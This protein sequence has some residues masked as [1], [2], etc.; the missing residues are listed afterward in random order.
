MNIQY[1]KQQ[2]IFLFLKD[3]RRFYIIIGIIMFTL[4][5]SAVIN[6]TNNKKIRLLLREKEGE[7][8]K[9]DLLNLINMSNKTISLYKEAFRPRDVFLVMSAVGDIAKSSG[10]KLSSIKPARE[11]EEPLYTRYYFNLDVEANSYHAIGKFVGEIENSPDTY[12]VEELDIKIREDG[13]ASGDKGAVQEAKPANKFTVNM[14]LS[15][16]SFKR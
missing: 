6:G 9:S 4:V 12:F 2:L 8:K 5:S 16:I 11:Q 15:I 14:A 7:T 1:T 10:V 3:K 13:A